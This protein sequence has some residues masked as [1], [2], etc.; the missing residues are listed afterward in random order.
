[1]SSFNL[2]SPRRH[3]AW[4]L[5]I[6][7]GGMCLCMTLAYQ[8]AWQHALR[9]ESENVQRQLGLHAQALAQRIDRYRTLP[10]VLSLDP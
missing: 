2:F 5:L 9:G 10:E 1:M 3:P 4:T 7:L 8:L 6:L